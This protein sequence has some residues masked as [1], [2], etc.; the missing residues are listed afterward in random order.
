MYYYAYPYFVNTHPSNVMPTSYNPMRHNS[1][2]IPYYNVQPNRQYPE[3]NIHEFEIS[4]Q[5]FQ[6]LMKQANLLINKIA[7]S[8]KFA[9]EIMTAAQKSD[10]QTVLKLIKS[11]GISIDV[12]TTFTPTSIRIYLDNSNKS[13]K[14]NCC[15]MLI[16]LR[17]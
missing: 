10:E 7:S 12:K 2:L 9:R 6:E 13:K 1:L 5:S 14:S 15:N 3:V 17:W 11:T 16:A 4:A 8:P